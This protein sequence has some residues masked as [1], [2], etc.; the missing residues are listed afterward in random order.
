MDSLDDNVSQSIR[1]AAKK[2]LKVLSENNTKLK[3]TT[4]PVFLSLYSDEELDLNNEKE[5]QEADE[6]ILKVEIPKTNDEINGKRLYRTDRT[7][8]T[9]SELSEGEIVDDDDEDILPTN[10]QKD[11]Q[12]QPESLLESRKLSLKSNDTKNEQWPARNFVNNRKFFDL[13]QR[14][15]TKQNRFRGIGGR[16]RNNS[17]FGGRLRRSRS[18]SHDRRPSRDVK[19]KERKSPTKNKSKPEKTTL[20]SEKVVPIVLNSEIAPLLKTPIDD[21][22]HLEVLKD[23]KQEKQKHSRK[24]DKK[25]EKHE[26]KSKENPLI[27]KAKE[28]TTFLPDDDDDIKELKL[29]IM[30]L[31]EELKYTIVDT[32]SAA[33]EQ[34]TIITEKTAPKIELKSPKSP[35]LTTLKKDEEKVEKKDVEKEKHLSKEKRPLDKCPDSKTLSKDEKPEKKKTRTISESKGTKHRSRSRTPKLV[36]KVVSETKKE[37]DLKKVDKNVSKSLEGTPKPVE[38]KKKER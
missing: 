21:V 28:L 23:S 12:K 6:E 15:Q 19:S 29:K 11:I 8:N 17:R 13:R 34:P 16:G 20:Q 18:R 26:K 14:I 22:D 32:E 24:K 2:R 27:E 1:D 25:H 10:I 38:S 31:Q 3:E 36:T 30:G 4:N 7:K 35:I 33:V 9:D 37:S 5:L